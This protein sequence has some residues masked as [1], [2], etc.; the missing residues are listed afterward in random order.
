MKGLS[1]QT[2]AQYKVK[3]NKKEREK[4]GK[5]KKTYTKTQ[6]HEISKNDKDKDRILKASREEVQ[7][8]FT[9]KTKNRA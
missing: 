2:N 1:F 6:H 4:Q 7:A 3:Q 8:K 9:L 5:E